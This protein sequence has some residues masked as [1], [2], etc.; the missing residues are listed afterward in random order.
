MIDQGLLKGWIEGVTIIGATFILVSLASVNDYSKDRQ[1]LKLLDKVKDEE[2]AVLRG[3]QGLTLGVKVDELVVGDIV[4]LETGS[5]VPSDCLLID[6][7]DI[8]VDE[9]F[10][11]PEGK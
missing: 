1:F 4:L 3:K 7:T 2:V 10:Y 6:G 9:R 8:S 5:R 11:H